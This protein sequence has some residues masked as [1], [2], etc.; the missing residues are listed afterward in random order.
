MK[1]LKYLIV[2]IALTSLTACLAARPPV[3]VEIPDLPSLEDGWS[4][5]FIGAGVMNGVKLW[6]ASGRSCLL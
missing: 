6:S 4:R 2:A 3:R 1:V 5:V